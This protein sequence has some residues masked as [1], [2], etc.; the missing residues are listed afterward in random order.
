MPSKINSA[1]DTLEI[2]LI[3]NYEEFSCI[4]SSFQCFNEN[5]GCEEHQRTTEGWEND[6]NWTWKIKGSDTCFQWTRY[7]DVRWRRHHLV[8][9]RVGIS[10]Q[11]VFLVGCT[12][13]GL[14]WNRGDLWGLL[15]DIFASGNSRKFFPATQWVA[16]FSDRGCQVVE[17]TCSFD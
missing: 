1:N 13:V 6:D 4:D 3:G 15:S 10:L 2:I 8:V 12:C 11:F 7:H 17:W 9:M 5:E 14:C 16:A